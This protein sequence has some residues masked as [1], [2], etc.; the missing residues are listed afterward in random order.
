MPHCKKDDS[1][2]KTAIDRNEK[3]NASSKSKEM[4]LNTQANTVAS[5]LLLHNHTTDCK[6]HILN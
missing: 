5:H 6:K 2:K 3:A 4:Q 1:A